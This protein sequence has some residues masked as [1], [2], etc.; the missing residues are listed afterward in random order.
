MKSQTRAIIGALSAIGLCA[1]AGFAADANRWPIV[2]TAGL[3]AVVFA[4]ITS[5]IVAASER[6]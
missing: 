1:V 3:L 6:E 2:I 4:I 5:P